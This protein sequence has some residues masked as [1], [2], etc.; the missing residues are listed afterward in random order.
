MYHR[1]CSRTR[2][3]FKIGFDCAYCIYI[4]HNS[5]EINLIIIPAWIKK[6]IGWD[7]SPNMN[8]TNIPCIDKRGRLNKLWGLL[9]ENPY[10]RPCLAI[11]SFLY[12][13]GVYLREWGFSR[14]IFRVKHLPRPV[15]SVGNLTLGGT[16]KTPVV[17]MI[18]KILLER[19]YHPI[20]LSRGYKRKGGRGG[21]V[22]S[23]G[24][25]VLCKQEEAGDEPYMLA[26]QLRKVPVLIGPDRYC[27]GLKALEGCKADCFILDD[28]FQ[29]FRLF[30]E[31]DILVINGKHPFCGGRLF[32]SGG[33]REPLSALK[34]ASLIFINSHEPRNHHEVRNGHDRDSLMNR[35][36]NPIIN[37]IRDRIRRYNTHA[38][39]YEI[40]YS[41]ESLFWAQDRK[42]RLTPSS[43]KGKTVLAFSGIGMPEAFLGQLMQLG[44]DIKKSVIFDDHHWFSSKEIE[45]I[46][47]MA[48][49]SNI[50]LVVTTEKDWVRLPGEDL[51]G[52]LVLKMEMRLKG[53]AKALE[54]ILSTIT[55]K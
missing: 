4:I 24:E 21:V 10:L 39:V 46:K 31:R 53:G 37:M 50:E 20:I 55:V 26:M 51:E 48:S 6:P 35:D 29:H 12:G 28:G 19:G 52:I 47:D 11:I 40:N 34:R 25:S 13:I 2:R 8:D 1:G 23:N 36:R 7:L 3:I 14:G 18:A 16:G 41:P 32:P 44:A 45:R 54:G 30:R 5:S 43:I 33:L 17:A 15:I 38:P 22:V 42:D 27:S 9:R 49:L